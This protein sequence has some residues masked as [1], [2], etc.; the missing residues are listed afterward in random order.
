MKIIAATSCALIFR[1]ILSLLLVVLPSSFI[2]GQSAFISIDGINVADGGS[3][4][5]CQDSTIVFDVLATG[6][7]GSPTYSWT[8]Q[9]GT[10]STSTTKTPS[11]IFSS[12]GAKT[13]TVSVYGTDTATSTITV[14]PTVAITSVAAAL[15]G[16]S[17]ICYN[18][19]PGMMTATP[20]GGITPID[21][22]WERKIGTGAWQYVGSNT[23]T[24]TETA[25]LTDNSEYRVTAT[26][27]SSCG[28]ATSN[29]LSVTV[30][31]AITPVVIGSSL[32][33]CHNS[34]PNLLTRN[35]AS[36]GNGTFTYQWQYSA[37][38]TNNWQN[39]G[40][41]GL[42][43][44][45]DTLTADRW[46]RVEVG[47]SCGTSYS[48]IIKITVRAALNAGSISP[49]ASQLCLNGSQALALSGTTGGDSAYS[50]MWETKPVGTGTWTGAPGATNSMNYNTGA[51]SQSA[52]Y[53]V[54]V[55]S[56]C[57]VEAISG[58]V[59]VNVAAALSIGSITL[60]GPSSL[61]YSTL[62]GQMTISAV[63][64]RTPYS[65]QWERKIGA[66]AW[67]NVGV[68]SNSFTESTNLTANTAYRVTV[69]SASGC[70]SQ[71]SGLHSITVFPDISV[72]TILSAQTICHNS[73]PA[74]LSRTNATGADGTFVYE[75]QYS[76]NG[77]GNWQ[78]TG[79]GG[80]SYSPGMLTADR[81]FRVR[82]DNS[83]ET[84]YSNIIKV[85]VRA[86]LAAGTISPSSP[87]ICYNTSQTLTVSGT[88]GSDTV[89]SYIWERKPVGI[90]S[91]TTAPGSNSSNTYNTGNLTQSYEYRV[92][93]NSGCGVEDITN[94][95]TVDVAEQLGIGTISLVGPSIICHSTLPGQMSIVASGG[96][97]P[98]SYQWER[99]IGAGAW[100]NV[101]TN[102]NIYSE[103]TLLTAD[104]EY[105]V[106]ATSSAGCGA[107]TSA[108]QTIIVRPAITAPTI[109]SAQTICYNSQA[110]FLT[111]TNATG[112]D[113]T[114]TYDWEYSLTGTS[115]WV[116]T[117]VSST[118]Y[119]PGALT[120][121]R[122]YRV[123]AVNSTCNGL[124]YSNIIKINV[125]NIL[126]AGVLSPDSSEICHNNSMALS[127]SNTTGADSTYIYTWQRRQHGTTNWLPAP[128][129]LN[130]ANYNTG[131]LMSSYAYRVIVNTSCNVTDTTNVAFVDVAAQFTGGS[132]A[133]S[134]NEDS[135]CY[136]QPPALLTAANFNGG[137][138][139]YTYMW[140]KKDSGSSWNIVGSNT[141]S[142][143]DPQPLL[144]DTY[145]RLS[146]NSNSSCGLITTD[147]ILI[148]VN[149]LPGT[150]SS[151]I[152]G[153][154]GVCG[155]AQGISYK[156]YP[157]Y[158]DSISWHIDN[159]IVRVNNADRIIVDFND[160][161]M[162]ITDTLYA[163]LKSSNTL[164]ER[165]VKIPIAITSNRAP[166]KTEITRKSNSTILI[167]A[168][169][170]AGMTYEWGYYE[171]SNGNEVIIPGANLRY[172]QYPGA[173]DT[174][175]NLYFV[176]TTL[177]G[178]SSTSYYELRS[179][180]F[181]DDELSLNNEFVLYPNPSSGRA[182][183]NGPLTKIETV[184]LV[185]TTGVQVELKFEPDSGRIYLPDIPQGIY[186]V[187]IK[188]ADMY[189]SI[190]LSIVRP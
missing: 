180:P 68:N 131:N 86:P 45:P 43:Y 173:I 98:F 100:Q 105:R 44:N 172:C 57:G 5:G 40:Q 117:G 187:L 30:L 79:Q 6:V 1:N 38:G 142:F 22:Q 184:F 177:N 102:S 2:C 141:N 54:R 3:A 129:A 48:N 140:E 137:R 50:Y 80:I 9:D 59:T 182:N 90:G 101:G 36:G 15:T 160:V 149:P 170:A 139:P 178:C 164:C 32:T 67:Q 120:A 112:A 11:V 110:A 115:N 113:G 133:I 181:G 4:T 162:A 29:L 55:N 183:L 103:T 70:G 188:T 123:K 171:R 169:S 154:Y 168:D 190:Y 41:T 92:R 144:K 62:P 153:S 12:T 19:V 119:N 20:T 136:N 56:G 23:N 42:T 34:V 147:S 58:V 127:V 66:G 126:I 175:A 152:M 60:S 93:V 8:F 166:D 118:S 76:T 81:W 135:V 95:I 49:S 143:Q 88:S 51:L 121:S 85:T 106:T 176:R 145:Y 39:T 114:F 13:V 167:C 91:W 94:V 46:F 24:Y 71:T 17:T 156:L 87:Q 18:T 83:C 64:G 74:L 150:D 21:Y 82:V 16:S 148:R 157:G 116:S 52:E 134:N 185:S 108:T 14:T 158:S 37:N 84:T 186:V 53:R 122:W 31:P 146:V 138:Q 10:P 124:V 125:R 75:W 63:G 155:N 161:G 47:N 61:C 89:Y 77:T 128:N 7:G 25:N 174:I 130:S 26:S 109:S 78:N 65:Y 96:R 99:K 104:T 163:F 35:N 111:R 73:Q 179:K 27:S 132:I 107:V 33:I 69:T 189:Q 165:V 97:T 159:A 28:S 151:F 72:P